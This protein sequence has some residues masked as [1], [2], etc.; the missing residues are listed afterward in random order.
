M[1]DGSALQQKSEDAE[2]ALAET[3]DETQQHAEHQSKQLLAR[4]GDGVKRLKDEAK[5]NFEGVTDTLKQEGAELKGKA[6][7]KIIDVKE[8]AGKMAMASLFPPGLTNLFNGKAG[9]FFDNL[10]KPLT[11][12]TGIE[13]ST[14]MKIGM[15]LLAGL[16]LG[17]LA[18]NNKG[19]GTLL[20]LVGV[21]G[22]AAML[23]GGDEAEAKDPA[24]VRERDNLPQPSPS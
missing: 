19:M 12:M 4:A 20:G 11:D 1:G 13:G 8:N 5:E 2:D 18:G 14:M 6:G 16:A 3:L 9:E 7:R 17:S 21:I 22:T 10:L 24:P 15:T 23:F